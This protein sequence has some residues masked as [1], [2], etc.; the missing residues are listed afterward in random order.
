MPSGPDVL[1][2]PCSRTARKSTQCR[3]KGGL[4]RR[5]RHCHCHPSAN[6]RRKSEIYYGEQPAFTANLL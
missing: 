3:V 1:R 4:S 2:Q 5:R 6:A